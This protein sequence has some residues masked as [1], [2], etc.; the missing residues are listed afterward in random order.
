MD[1][2]DLLRIGEIVADFHARLKP[3]DFL[4][5]Q[6]KARDAFEQYLRIDSFT[7]YLMD[8]LKTFIEVA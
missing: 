5:M 6:K 3:D 4:A 1:Y 8:R 7:K 2:K